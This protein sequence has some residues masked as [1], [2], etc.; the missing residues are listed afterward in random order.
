MGTRKE[1][2]AVR[3]FWDISFTVAGVFQYGGYQGKI[4]VGS[5]RGPRV[6]GVGTLC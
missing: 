6:F 5:R 2:G 3:V 4:G 1:R